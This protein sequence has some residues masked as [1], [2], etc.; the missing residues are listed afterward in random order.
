MLNLIDTPGHADFSYEVSRSLAACDGAILL[1]DANEGVQAQTVA[2]FWLAF[3]NELTILPVLNK[4]DLERAD[5][6]RVSAQLH[7]LFD[8]Q[9]D[10]ILRIS[11][12]TGL[13]VAEQLLPAIV[14]RLPQPRVATSDQ[15]FKAFIFDSWF[16]KFHGSFASILVKSGSLI[17]G[18]Q[19]RAMSSG[20]QYETK[21]LGIMYPE[22][23]S[24]DSL[25]AGQVGYISAGMKTP[26][27]AR[28]GDTLCSA[29]DQSAE[30]LPGFQIPKP[31]VF[32]GVY[33]IDQSE[34]LA[35]RKA[36]DQLLLNDPAVSCEV[37]N[38]AALGQGWRLGFLGLLHL[39]VFSQRLDSEYDIPVVL[40]A[41]NVTYRA[42]IR[43]NAKILAKYDVTAEDPFFTI[44]EPAKFPL[45]TEVQQF[46]EPM[47]IATIVVPVTCY[48]R[49]VELC[50][51]SRGVEENQEYIDD[52]RIILK[53]RLP[54]S[55]VI[56][57]FYD[58]LK[59]ITSGYGSF[60][61]E[62]TDYKPV[63]LKKLTVVLN[64]NDVEEFSQIV[65]SANAKQRAQILASKLKSEIPQQIIDIT[66]Q[67]KSGGKVLARKEIRAKR[68]DV[69]AKLY[70]G[71]ITR[72]MK[73]LKNQEKGK[74]R[75][76]ML[77][78]VQV[79]KSTFINVVKR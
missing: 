55:E 72:R 35:V 23:L 33:P 17:V 79:P 43:P 31:V 3:E 67:V 24:T 20:R 2:N 5:V 53:Y 27:E 41:P 8:F 71:D 56:V 18:Q 32:A 78:S 63:S 13:N 66:I 61:Y 73:V 68:K 50:N 65:A 26:A 51:E 62:E 16:E 34:N 28:V 74:E 69:T 22:K 40:T 25:F 7:K 6:D 37:T 42:Q 54:L 48:E 59:R 70:G 76:K 47:V 19:I 58:C 21:E 11:A 10:E 45:S 4:I 15:P 36:L 29:D 46:Y 60:D 44:T 30:S 57:D 64:K 77:H 52:G 39:E 1:V 75:M 49:V 14:D 12:K 9:P 38:S